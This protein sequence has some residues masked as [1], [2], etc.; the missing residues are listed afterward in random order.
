M[1]SPS[2]VIQLYSTFYNL[3]SCWSELNHKVLG[4]IQYNRLKWIP[5]SNSPSKANKLN[6]SALWLA[7]FV[8]IRHISNSLFAV[9]CSSTSLFSIFLGS[10]F[11]NNKNLFY[12]T[13]YRICHN[14]FV[15]MLQNTSATATS[16]ISNP[17]VLC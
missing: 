4:L 14:P 10:M 3:Q 13:S 6:E 8:Q 17:I 15:R 11:S 7:C 2:A 1:S 12:F 16:F 5:I 9:V